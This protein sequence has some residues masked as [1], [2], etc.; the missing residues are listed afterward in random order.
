M[1]LGTIFPSA[2]TEFSTV[3]LAKFYRN[4]RRRFPPIRRGGRYCVQT[5]IRIHTSRQNY[6]VENNAALLVQCQQLTVWVVILC[7]F[8]CRILNALSNTADTAKA[9]FPPDDYVYR[10]Q[11]V[12]STTTTSS[13]PL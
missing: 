5:Y 8:N 7:I 10:L 6:I 13:A 4:R 2:L 11:A 12:L 3:L 9:A 1:G